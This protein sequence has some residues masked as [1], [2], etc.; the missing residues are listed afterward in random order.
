MA[1]V[2]EETGTAWEE[3]DVT[4]DEE[5]AR[6]Y[7]DLVPVVLVDG[8]LVDYWRVDAAQLRARLT[9]PRPCGT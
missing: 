9:A 4:A 2:A 1:T 7:L 8:E 5:D 6:Q 3:R